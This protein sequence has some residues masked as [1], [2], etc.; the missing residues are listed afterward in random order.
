MPNRKSPSH[1][2]N[3]MHG[4]KVYHKYWVQ[5]L[6]HLIKV[7]VKKGHT[8]LRIYSCKW[9]QWYF[10]KETAPRHYHIG[11]KDWFIRREGMDRSQ[12]QSEGNTFGDGNRDSFR[13]GPDSP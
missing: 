5:A 9:G 6:W 7:R 2:W 1:R 10:R 13:D 4:T 11:R 3:R 8:G 12:G